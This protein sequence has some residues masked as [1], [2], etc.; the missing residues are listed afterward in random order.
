[1]RY[2]TAEAF[3]QALEA[4]LDREARGSGKPLAYLRKRVAF[5]RFL[6]RV[7]PPASTDAPFVLK[8]AFALGLR[9][10]E[11]RT[12]QDLDLAL[13]AAAAR[14]DTDPVEALREAVERDMDDFFQFRI[15]KASEMHNQDMANL[16][17]SVDARL[18]GRTFERFKLDLAMEVLDPASTERRV[19]PTY[20]EFAGMRAFAVRAIH[21]AGH[22]ADKL[23]AYSRPRKLRSRV[24]DLV[25]LAL[26][27]LELEGDPE[28]SKRVQEEVERIYGQY[29]THRPWKDLPK[30]PSDWR[31]AFVRQAKE[32]GLE[33][34]TMKYWFNRVDAF[35]R[36]LRPNP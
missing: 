1:V 24:K 29:A 20:L 16:R 12:T 33:P 11:R 34:P 30:P 14:S 21:P 19:V 15:G 22:Y 36:R 23:H 2:K 26:L 13:S 31:A 4:T 18:A 32:V 17:L 9:V 27:T 25:D 28:A 35:Y 7:F 8:G 3:R 10:R 5:E 6:V